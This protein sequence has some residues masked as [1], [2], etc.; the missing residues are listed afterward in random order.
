[1]K[2]LQTIRIV[3][4]LSI[5]PRN[6]NPLPWGGQLVKS[7]SHSIIVQLT[8]SL[9]SL[10]TRRS[11]VPVTW[12]RCERTRRLCSD[13]E[14]WIGDWGRWVPA[15]KDYEVSLFRVFLFNPYF[16]IR[17]EFSVV[18]MVSHPPHPLCYYSLVPS[19]P[20]SPRSIPRL[21]SCQWIGS[22][23]AKYI[24][25]NISFA[26]K[27]ELKTASFGLTIQSQEY[28]LLW[29]MQDSWDRGPIVPSP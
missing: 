13:F 6:A 4:R 7:T 1:M 22:S 25:N 28:S 12:R 9:S 18:V 14:D 20:R 27:E 23:A 8:C 21:D 3:I 24:V 2:L 17:N 26:P 10:G 15:I 29:L 16:N 19:S 11:G 5:I